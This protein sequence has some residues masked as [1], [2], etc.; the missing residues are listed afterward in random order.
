MFGR[1]DKAHLR[2]VM[3]GGVWNIFLL[4]KVRGE[5]VLCRFRGGADGDGH[6]FWECVLTLPL[7][8]IVKNLNFIIS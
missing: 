3:V 8:K 5:V 7:L 1:D 2:S 6:P 4:V